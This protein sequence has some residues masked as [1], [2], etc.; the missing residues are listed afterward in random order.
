MPDKI[1]SDRGPQFA[2]QF[3]RELCRLLSTEL[4]L[5]SAYHPEM[6]GLVERANQTLVTYLPHFVSA[7]QDDWASL[8][9]WV[10]F[11]PT[12]PVRLLSSLITASIRG[13]LCLCPVFHRLQGGRLGC[14]GFGHLVPHSGC[15][16]SL[17]GEDEV[18]CRCTSAPCSDLCYWRLS[19]VL[20]WNIRLRVESTKF[21]PCY[22]GPFKVLEQVNP[23]VY[24]L[25]LPPRLGITDTFHVSLLKP[26]YMSRFSESSAGKSDLSMDDYKVKAIFGCKVVLGKTFYL[27][28]WKGYG[29]EDR[30]WEPAEHIRA[31]QLIAAFEHSKVQGGGMTYSFQKHHLFYHMI[32]LKSGKNFIL[33]LAHCLPCCSLPHRLSSML[34][35]P[36]QTVLHVILSLTNCPPCYSR[37]HRLTSMLF[38]PSQTVLHFK[39]SF[40]LFS[41]PQTVHH[42]ILSLTDCIHVILSLTDCSPCYSPPHRL[43]SMFFSPS[44]TFPHV[45]FILSAVSIE[46]HT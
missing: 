20:P 5:S 41:P 8:L 4:N 15:H 43:S 36:S 24:H 35:S 10:E 31:L 40:M 3:W 14:R 37:P 33:S 45:I 44:Q 42:V 17:Q 2:S 16:K 18:L 34:F 39:L 27:V 13:F 29:P 6:N 9:P 23:V 21:A 19:V 28:D 25:A 32:N 26:V 38:L 12:P 7:R 1:V 22:L 11:M 46:G 30:S